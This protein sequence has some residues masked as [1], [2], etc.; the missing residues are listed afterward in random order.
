MNKGVRVKSFQSSNIKAIEISI[1]DWLEK[2]NVEVVDIKINGYNLDDRR[3][4][5]IVAIVIYK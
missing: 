3:G 2:N 4:G 1:N 5:M